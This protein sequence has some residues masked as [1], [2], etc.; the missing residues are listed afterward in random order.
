MKPPINPGTRIL[1]VEGGILTVRETFDDGSFKVD[2]RASP[3][4]W[5]KDFDFLDKP[6]IREGDKVFATMDSVTDS[7]EIFH[8]RAWH[9]YDVSHVYPDRGEGV[10]KTRF[11][12][13]ECEFMRETGRWCQKCV[14][15]ICTY[16]NYWGFHSS[17]ELGSS[18]HSAEDLSRAKR[19]P[20][21]SEV[22]EFFGLRGKP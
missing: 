9:V 5:S 18:L 19:L 3:I 11:C 7:D 17:R 10:W 4:S 20:E 15:G 2:D 8:L 14:G 1:V 6:P 12:I 21:P 22:A 13:L 16:S